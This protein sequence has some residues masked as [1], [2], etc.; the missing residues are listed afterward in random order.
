MSYPGA[1]AATAPDRPAV[2]MAGTGAVLTYGQLEDR[3]ARLAAA[4][5][6]TGLRSGD[7]IA[8]LT[9][10]TATA[11][12]VYW[13]A[14]RSGLYIT[15]I[16]WH[17]APEEAAYIVSDSGAKVVFCSAGVRDLGEQVAKIEKEIRGGLAGHRI[18]RRDRATLFG[19]LT[20]RVQPG[21]AS[22]SGTVDVGLGGLDIAVE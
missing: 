12:E 11:F 10:N 15:A 20:G 16:N 22:E 18:V 17:L 21:D 6:I 2:V 9:D 14:L 1:H 19:D 7:V 5:H 13:A 3:S 8:L 4:L